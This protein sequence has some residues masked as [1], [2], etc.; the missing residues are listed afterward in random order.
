[1]KTF[2]LTIIISLSFFSCTPE[3]NTII[4]NVC[5]ITEEICYYANLICENYNPESDESIIDQKKVNELK[6]YAE[7]LKYIYTS[8][9]FPSKANV[10]LSSKMVNDK[11]I[12][13]R[14]QLKRIAEQQQLLRH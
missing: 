13:V 8:Q 4:S 10:G 5:E 9:Q 14:D 2:L 12:E 3:T 11:L 6:L 7:D 1:M